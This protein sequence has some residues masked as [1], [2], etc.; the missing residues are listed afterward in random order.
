MHDFVLRSVDIESFDFEIVGLIDESPL[1]SIPGGHIE[2]VCGGLAMTPESNSASESAHAHAEHVTASSAS[3]ESVY[4][5]GRV[6]GGATKKQGG[7]HEHRPGD[8]MGDRS[9]FINSGKTCIYQR[10]SKQCSIAMA[11][12]HVFAPIR[13]RSFAKKRIVSFVLLRSSRKH[14]ESQVHPTLLV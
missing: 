13:H 11:Y 4:T 1:P 12:S 8:G 6:F 2:Q 3:T 10:F 14:P 5:P 9:T 7:R